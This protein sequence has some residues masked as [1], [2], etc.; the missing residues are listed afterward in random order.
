VPTRSAGVSGLGV[1]VVATGGLLVYAGIRDVP[2]LDTLRQALRGEVPAPAEK[3]TSS[4]L[5]TIRAHPGGV[6]GAGASAGAAANLGSPDAASATGNALVNAARRYLGRPYVW[7]GTFQGSA[8]GDCS[9]LVQR[10]FR[11]IGI[12]DCP[13]TSGQIAAWSKLRKVTGTPAAGDVL[14]WSGHVAIATSSTQMIEAPT[15]GIPVRVTG[16]RR[17]ALVLRYK[18]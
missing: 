10:S 13:R 18:G 7:G 6:G 5:E 2:V 17:G 9:G 11:D 16:I 12:A 4:W 14:W 1:T 3:S 15:F 8:G